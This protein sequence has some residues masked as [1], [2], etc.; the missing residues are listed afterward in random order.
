MIDQH[1][2]DRLEFTKVI[3]LIEGQCLT[4]FGRV[5]VHAFGP[6]YDCPTI[7]VRQQEIS[8]MKDLLNFG[9]PFPLCRIEDCRTLLEKSRVEGIFLDPKEIF[10][11]LELVELS[12]ALHAYDKEGRP[13][14]PAISSHLNKLRPFP[15]LVRDIKKA[16]DERGE[17][18]DDAS[19]HLRSTRA[20]IGDSRRRI[21]RQL[22]QTLSSQTKQAG[23]QDDIVTQ[24]NGRYVI[25]VPA[26]LYRADLGILHD[27]SQSGATFFIEPKETVEHNNRL[28]M[29]LQE[30]R[31][32]MD[33]ILRALTRQIAERADKLIDNIDVIGKLDSFHAAASFARQIKANRPRL[34]D[35]PML[36]LIDARHPLLIAQFGTVDKV[37]PM[38]LNLDE[39]RQ[40]VLVTG[41][42]TGGKTIMLKTVGLVVLMAQSGL[43]IPADEKSQV[44]IFHKVFAD[45]GDEQSIE[46]SLST[47]S[48]HITNIINAIS[49]VSQDSLVLFDEIGA[50]T[51]PKEGAA[52][53][54]AVLLHI[55]KQGAKLLATTHYSQLKTLPLDHPAIENA[56]L[57][58]NRD[59]LAPTYR[60]KLGLP[61]SSYALEIAGRLGMP[62]AVCAHALKLLGTGERSLADLISSVEAQLARIRADQTDLSERLARAKSLETEYQAKLETFKKDVDSERTKALEETSS[63]LDETRKETERLV[64]EIR[65]SQASKDSIKQ[66]QKKLK[67]ST[68][69]VSDL[70]A[71]QETER[72]RSIDALKFLKGDPVRIVTLNKEGQIDSLVGHDRAKVKVGNIMTVVEIRNLRHI[73]SVMPSARIKPVAGQNLDEVLSPEIHLRGM[74]AEE[75][76]EALERFLDKAIVAGLRQVYVIHGKGT[77]ALRRALTEYLREHKEVASIRLGDWNEGGAG[78]T[79]VELKQ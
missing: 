62:E 15:E 1:T 68:A 20:E 45:I 18:K 22:E 41:P 43:P 24:R 70:K 65:A 16:I 19:P 6:M 66:L 55:V 56:S 27:R 58:F 50:G 5:E 26:N 2:L 73:D 25:P 14:F 76:K 13:K 42:N 11:V 10:V 30:E 57:E 75:G 61:G 4:P 74:T 40:A 9:L 3:S 33:R 46:L 67:E 39:S 77:G 59:T 52:L 44:G 49:Q 63:L 69:S 21:L 35:S 54:E 71:K 29:L 8:E 36:D 37:V 17:I 78:V 7:E 53:A 28:N 51:D 79:I 23:W 48:S 60:L 32:E 31:L 38:S 72:L 12:I 47:F 34:V 64:A